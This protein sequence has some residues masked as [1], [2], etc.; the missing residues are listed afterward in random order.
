MESA[1]VVE[2][3]ARSGVVNSTFYDPDTK[4]GMYE[5]DDILGRGTFGKVYAVFNKKR[6][7]HT[8][9]KILHYFASP[10]EPLVAGNKRTDS[11][12]I[13]ACKL[14]S[15]DGFVKLYDYYMCRGYPVEENNKRFK[16]I[17]FKLASSSKAPFC[18]MEMQRAQGNMHE[19]LSLGVNAL[20]LVDKLLFF[21]EIVFALNEALKATGLEHRD[22]APRNILFVTNQ[23]ARTY[24]IGKNTKV[25][26][27]GH[28]R[29]LIA[30]FGMSNIRNFPSSHK[31]C[32]SDLNAL[33]KVANEWG[34][35]L[36]HRFEEVR[37]IGDSNF[38]HIG[39]I[40]YLSTYK[41]YDLL[42]WLIYDRIIQ[43]K[44]ST[45]IDNLKAAAATTTGFCSVC[46]NETPMVH[47]ESKR[48]F[49]GMSCYNFEK[50][51]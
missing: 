32:W 39:E 30:D 3:T 43:L 27:N 20:T 34:F 19:I 26:V 37:F 21:F 35:V 40:S 28:F 18:Y 14:S 36:L 8:A 5:L 15:I 31:A 13:I 23:E 9:L 2:D 49:C 17:I 42:L 46:N 7:E 25:V 11:E 33:E 4:L 51:S 24:E 38:P 48:F 45:M 44:N 16:S 22:I 1:T 12:I 50:K 41:N 10:S 6:Q 47:L 29:P